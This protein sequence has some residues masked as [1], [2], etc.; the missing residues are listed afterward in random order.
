MKTPNKTLVVINLYLYFIVPYVS[1]LGNGKLVLFVCR[2]RILNTKIPT[3]QI[4]LPS[5]RFHRD[6]PSL[7]AGFG[8]CGNVPGIKFSTAGS[9]GS[10]K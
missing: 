10:L 5:S 6:R 7:C 1:T 2:H 9:N 3:L 4:L 8:F